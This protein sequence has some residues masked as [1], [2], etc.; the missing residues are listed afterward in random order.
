MKLNYYDIL[1]VA[2]S[3][4]QEVVDAAYRAMMKKYHPDMWKGDPAVGEKK[5]K[6]LNEAYAI[7]KDPARRKQYDAQRD[8]GHARNQNAGTQGTKREPPKRDAPKQEPP[9]RE[10]PK[11]EAPKREP[12]TNP[13]PKAAKSPIFEPH[14]RVSLLRVLVFFIPLVILFGL[15]SAYPNYATPVAAPA[16][17]DIANE[18]S[19]A[20]IIT[21]PSG[22]QYRVLEEGIGAS[23]TLADVVLIGY[24]GSLLDGTVFDENPQSAVPVDGVVPG[25]SEGLQKMK[26]GGKYRL[27]IPPHLGYGPQAAGPIPPNSTLVFEVN[28]HDF[29]TKAEVMR[30]K[31]AMRQVE[32]SAASN[33]AE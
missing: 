9:K 21:T 10:P 13:A 18:E 15:V 25:F 8:A 30:I 4:E 31:E 29:K 20:D 22:L 27:L 33:A 16:S 2:P 7:L 19:Q 5:A 23:P 1:G 3:S 11:K 26:R 6:L 28:M 24:K 17:E 14:G 12:H 32:G